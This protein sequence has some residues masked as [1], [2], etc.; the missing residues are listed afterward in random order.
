MMYSKNATAFLQQAKASG[1][2]ATADGLGML[3]EQAAES[4][5]QWRELRPATESVIA[6][7]R[8]AM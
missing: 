1:A 3:V 6:S 2:Q 7:I 8:D 5:Y 4:F